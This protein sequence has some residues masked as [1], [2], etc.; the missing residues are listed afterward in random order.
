MKTGLYQIFDSVAQ[1]PATPIIGFPREEAAIRWFQETAV[2]KGDNNPVAQY[3]RDHV[4]LKLGFQNLETGEIDAHLPTPV[5]DGTMM[6]DQIEQQSKTEALRA[7]TP[8]SAPAANGAADASP[9][10]I[11]Q[12]TPEEMACLVCGEHFNAHDSNTRRC[13]NQ[14]SFFLP[15]EALKRKYTEYLRAQH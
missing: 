2:R 6:L 14:K 4:L 12:P 7:G 15:T 13:R 9:G 5:Y 1:L 11:E 3:P 10:L 8:G